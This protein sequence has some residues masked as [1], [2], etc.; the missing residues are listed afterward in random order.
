MRVRGGGFGGIHT[1]F[2]LAVTAKLQAPAQAVKDGRRP[3]AKMSM[4]V[5]AGSAYI[6]P[7]EKRR[8]AGNHEPD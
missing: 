4:D 1:V 5:F 3:S 2:P 8:G 7:V 6:R